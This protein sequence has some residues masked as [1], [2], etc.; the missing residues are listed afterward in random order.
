[1]YTLNEEPKKINIGLVL[2]CNKLHIDK[3][4]LMTFHTNEHS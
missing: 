2:T 3:I 4:K 1:M